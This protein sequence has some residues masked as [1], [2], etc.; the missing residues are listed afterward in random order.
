MTPGGRSR[1]RPHSKGKPM[2][3]EISNLIYLTII[4]LD[5]DTGGITDIVNI[6]VTV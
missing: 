4:N 5:P 3:A 6:P 1:L 2:G